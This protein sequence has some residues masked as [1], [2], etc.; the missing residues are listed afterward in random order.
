MTV[1]ELIELLDDVPLDL[2]V[3]LEGGVR[4][5]ELREVFLTRDLDTREL[6]AYASEP[7][8]VVLSD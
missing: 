2:E 5:T 7:D 1:K 8:C 4:T 6:P 3:R